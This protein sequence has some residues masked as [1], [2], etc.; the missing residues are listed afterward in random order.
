LWA[1]NYVT[2]L[3]VAYAT[4]RGKNP[5]HVD[6]WCLEVQLG[7]TV[8]QLGMWVRYGIHVLVICKEETGGEAS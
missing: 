2:L 4:A 5:G 3:Y 7:R 1:D 8:R 6:W